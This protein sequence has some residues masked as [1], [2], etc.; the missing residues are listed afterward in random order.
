MCSIFGDFLLFYTM[1]CVGYLR[2][3]LDLWQ[4]LEDLEVWICKVIGGSHLLDALLEVLV[5][6]D[7][8]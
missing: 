3:R 8:S 1:W 5:T 6:D 4:A 2:Y 7:L